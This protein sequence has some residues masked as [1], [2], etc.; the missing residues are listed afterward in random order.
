MF[1][2]AGTFNIVLQQASLFEIDE[3]EDGT[4]CLD[5]VNS[6]K[7]YDLILMDIMMPNMSGET[8]IKKLD[9]VSFL[10]ISIYAIPGDNS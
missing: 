1:I 9:I 10:S 3:A 8:A 7:V 5:K 4:I 6:G 2:T